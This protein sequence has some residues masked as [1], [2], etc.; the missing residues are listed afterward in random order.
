MIKTAKFIVNPLQENTYLLYDETLECVIIDAGFHY[1]DEKSE[2]ISVITDNRLKPVKLINTH[3]HFDHMLGI[4]FL[5]KEYQIPF[6]A[7]EEDVFLVEQ[8]VEQGEMFGFNMHPVSFPEHYLTT[9]E[10]V[11][12]GK[13]SLNVFHVPGHSPGHVV[14]YSSEGNFMITGDV[15][16][17]GSIGRTDL[18]GGNYDTLIQGIR[19]KLFVLP[20]E[21]RVYPGHG[22][23][24]TI[25]FEKLNN[26]FFK[27]D[28]W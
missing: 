4:E 10:P 12:F 5:R 24:T 19:G 11:R 13:S 6:Y 22:P 21:T 26:P 23:E 14:F 9:D 25:G 27:M 18:P 1:R 16:F 7:H 3:C 17:R 20:D 2:I 8:A 28:V 15:L